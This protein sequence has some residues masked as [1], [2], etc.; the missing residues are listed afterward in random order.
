[1]NWDGNPLSQTFFTQWPWFDFLKKCWGVAIVPHKISYICN[2]SWLS[3]VEQK[4]RWC[5]IDQKIDFWA[6][7]PLPSLITAS[8]QAH[9]PCPPSSNCLL[10]VFPALLNNQ[11][12]KCQVPVNSCLANMALLTSS[13][14]GCHLLV[15]IRSMVIAKTCRAGTGVCIVVLIPVS[16]PDIL[17]TQKRAKG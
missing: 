10:A 8:S 17:T 11:Y 14:L 9:C 4:F 3:N 12:S 5:K 2:D 6:S 15:D 7:L 16:R 1:M 13:F